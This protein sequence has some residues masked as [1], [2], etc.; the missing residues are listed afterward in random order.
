MPL[1]VGQT[2]SNYEVLDSIGAGAMG[3][4]YRARDTKLGREV[5]IKLL[6]E[7]FVEDA[8][9]L[10][11]FER[12]ARTLASLNHP[13][14]GAIHGIEESEGLHFLALE[15]IPGQ[16]LSRLIDAGR[17]TLSESLEI[18]RQIAEGLEAAHAAGVVHR[19]LKP[20]NVRVTP[21]GNVKVV[22]FGLA[23]PCLPDNGDPVMTTELGRILGTPAYMSPEQVRCKP[24]D[25]RSDIWA[26]GCVL[27]ECLS[28]R[29]AFAGSTVADLFAAITDKPPDWS[30]LPASTP[31]RIRRMLERCL[32]KDVKQRLQSVGE[33]RILLE[34]PAAAEASLAAPSQS[35]RLAPL[36]G[37]ALLVIAAYSW[38]AL[39]SPES[40]DAPTLRLAVQLPPEHRLNLNNPRSGGL[41]GLAPP[42]TLTRDG[43]LLAYLARDEFLPTGLYVRLLSGYEVRRLAGTD[44]AEAPFFSPNGEWLG[45]F[46]NGGL[47]KVPVNGGS[48]ELICPISIFHRPSATWGPDGTIVF[49]RGINAE[50]RLETVSADGGVP[51]NLTVPDFAAGE[52]WHGL[53]QVLPDG[54]TVLFTLATRSGTRAALLERGSNTPR[55]IEGT[56]EASGARFLPRHDQ[57]SG[58]LL[59]TQA[60]RILAA[61]FDPASDQLIGSPWPVI[62]QLSCSALGVG[63]WAC[64]ENGSL[65]Y[66]S[67]QVA[68]TELVLTD[69]A[70]E[71]TW[72]SKE[73]GAYQHPRLS[74]D[75][76][77]LLFDR[78]KSGG[79]D[80]WL[81]D[82]ARD[83]ARPLTSEYQN[84]DP[85]WVPGEEEIIF[86]RFLKNIRTLH[87]LDVGR[88]GAFPE[89]ILGGHTEN[90]IAGTWSEDG[91]L[92]FTA[93][94]QEME[95]ILE[96][97]DLDK[98]ESTPIMS[99]R[100]RQGFP[101]LH[102]SGRLLAYVSNETGSLQV[103]V[104][105][106][107]DLNRKQ[108]ISTGLGSEPLFS[109]D[110]SELF[111][112]MG[113]DYDFHVAA[114]TVTEAGFQVGEMSKL[115][116]G[117]YEYSP[118]G[119]QHYDVSKDGQNFALVRTLGSEIPTE[120]RVIT[121]WR[122][123]EERE[124]R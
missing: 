22:D 108:Q 3:E 71:I 51:Q 59:F 69:R 21:E 33:A 29:R 80:I 93:L 9:Y 99:G 52:F 107:P 53:P 41:D 45:F 23:K 39:S 47:Y 66:I 32:T 46:Q 117:P 19:D 90:H 2:I 63:H 116:G 87:R 115:F 42:I 110:G 65:I 97:E 101:S 84:M 16:D 92:L 15:L 78:I 83:S 48:P 89:A 105:T 111:F 119:H 36:L 20:A 11:R 60:G 27:F 34:N 70:G 62:D 121:N 26:F 68:K 95:D 54:Q 58:L 5:A 44:N 118:T 50:G 120:L 76:S 8:E 72:R 103:Y 109:D 55:I 13:S 7:H 123:W 24:I 49:S 79:R 75:S 56:G 81:L 112:R 12:E 40:V 43:S 74:A 124:N 10:A 94:G 91:A 86:S 96:L 67:G 106:Y 85:V 4:V 25:S 102:P 61:N 73:L 82:I 88:V 100:G 98:G 37:A 114:I 1:Q 57:D 77:R 17:L 31:P 38:G 6:P 64:S 122:P 14:V 113:A 35:K 104:C 28:G 30:A 18:C